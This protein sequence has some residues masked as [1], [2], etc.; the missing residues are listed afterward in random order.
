MPLPFC[1]TN[2]SQGHRQA[3]THLPATPNQTANKMPSE[4]TEHQ[5]QRCGSSVSRQPADHP[6]AQQL[7]GHSS[8]HSVYVC[9][10]Q[11]AGCQCAGCKQLV[12][13]VYVGWALYPRHHRPPGHLCGPSTRVA[14]MATSSAR[15]SASSTQHTDVWPSRHHRRYSTSSCYACSRCRCRNC[16]CQCN[17]CM[18]PLSRRSGSLRQPMLSMPCPCSAGLGPATGAQ[19]PALLNTHHANRLSTTTWAGY[20]ASCSP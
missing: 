10:S 6:G 14:L 16:C 7:R 4:Q 13:C 12:E 19:Q 8:T 15:S 5:T 11:Q 2:E 17:G 9:T 1:T 3:T 20:T 18:L